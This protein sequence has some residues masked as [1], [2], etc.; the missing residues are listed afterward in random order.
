MRNLVTLLLA[1]RQSVVKILGLQRDDV[2]ACSL[3]VEAITL[4]WQI[5]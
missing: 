1:I 5:S 4:S 3:L 2:R